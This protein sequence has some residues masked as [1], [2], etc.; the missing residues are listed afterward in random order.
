MP[1][2]VPR[3]VSPASLSGH[4]RCHLSPSS[5]HTDVLQNGRGVSISR[6]CI[7]GARSE[8]CFV[9]EVGGRSPAICQLSLTRT[10]RARGVP[11][12]LYS[13]GCEGFA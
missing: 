9:H 3:L 8:V 5:T 12:N 11:L 13:A 2:S 6:I 1:T 7:V 4:S 10:V